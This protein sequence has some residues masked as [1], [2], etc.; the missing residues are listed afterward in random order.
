MLVAAPV[1]RTVPRSLPISMLM[2]MM[3]REIR[4]RANSRWTRSPAGTGPAWPSTGA[5]ARRRS[6]GGRDL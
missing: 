2:L 3:P 5:A 6:Q 1:L 4:M